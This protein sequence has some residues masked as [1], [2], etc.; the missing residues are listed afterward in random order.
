M[1]N[2]FISERMG[3]I[4]ASPTLP[5]HSTSFSYVLISYVTQQKCMFVGVNIAHRQQIATHG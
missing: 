5:V 4:A 3:A 2:N 1:L